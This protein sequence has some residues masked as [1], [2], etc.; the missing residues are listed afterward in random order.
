MNLLDARGV[1][2]V[3]DH[4]SFLRYPRQKIPQKSPVRPGVKVLS[5]PD[6]WTP[7]S[8]PDCKYF[9]GNTGWEVF[10]EN[11]GSPG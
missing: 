9:R 2:T 7:T 3:D 5:G 11:Y 6:Q 8:V 10:E 4:C 1:V